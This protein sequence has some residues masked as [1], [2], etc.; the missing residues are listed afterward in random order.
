MIS[1]V[2]TMTTRCLSI[3]TSLTSPKKEV[4]TAMFFDSH[5]PSC[6]TQNQEKRESSNQTLP[7]SMWSLYP[8][9][10][11]T[12]DDSPLLSTKIDHTKMSIWRTV[13]SLENHENLQDISKHPAPICGH[14]AA[15]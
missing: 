5:Q 7:C 8:L 14:S 4:P 9:M 2:L 13:N 1:I 3:R 10:R 6:C 15:S 12:G 11:K